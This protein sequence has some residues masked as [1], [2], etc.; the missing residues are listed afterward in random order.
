MLIAI[1]HGNYSIKSV[2]CEPMKAGLQES[3][4][5]PFGTDVLKYKG[6]FYQLSEQRIPYRR[7]KTED[8]RYFVLTLFA[9]AREIEAA[10]AYRPSII[11]IQLAI[12]LPPAHFGVQSRPFIRYFSDRGTINFSYRNRQYSVSISD[13]ACY[14]QSYAAAMTMYRE[15][16]SVPKALILDI[17]GY[18]VDYLLIKNGVGDLTICDSLENGIITL[19]NKIISRARS[20][21]D[22]QLAGLMAQVDAGNG[23]VP[24]ES[25]SNKNFKMDGCCLADGTEVNLTFEQSNII[26][27]YGIVTALNFMSLGWTARNNYTA[28]YPGNTDVKDQF[29]PVS[30]MFDFVANT[31]IRS[32]WS[33]LDKPMNLR[34]LDNI[35]DTC[36]IWL[37]GLVSSE[38][39]LGAR[40]EVR[41]EE[42]PATSLLA[43]I[44]SFHIYLTPPVPAQE[45]NFTLEFDV[46]Y[47]TS[48]LKL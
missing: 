16:A 35:Q 23:G 33:K 48:A 17:G 34:L 7:D 46:D 36:N 42:N 32:F 10:N 8:E 41:G 44:I 22:T 2:N 27:G 21:Q 4:V 12:G 6:K 15:L 37:N 47:L 30:R 18:T 1:D 19:Y 31:L 3:D 26:A 29:I 20:E 14:P 9:I 24:Y 25:P 43:G 11:P 38:Y 13:V 28:C 39:L 40:V 45:I 5:R